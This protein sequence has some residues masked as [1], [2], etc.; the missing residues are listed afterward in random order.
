MQLQL[1]AA[2][3]KLHPCPL[4]PCSHSQL[5]LR[6]ELGVAIH[7]LRLD[8]DKVLS[9]TRCKGMIHAHELRGFHTNEYDKI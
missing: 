3:H 8:Q 4:P 6:E 2:S 7:P 1:Q 9:G 5:V